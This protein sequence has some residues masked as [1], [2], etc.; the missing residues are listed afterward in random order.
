[1]NSIIT[2]IVF[3]QKIFSVNRK[4]I[5]FKGGFRSHADQYQWA[6]RFGVFGGDEKNIFCAG[7]EITHDSSGNIIQGIKHAEAQLTG[8]LGADFSYS[9][10]ITLGNGADAHLQFRIS[11]EGRYGIRLRN[12]DVP[13]LK[14]K[15]RPESFNCSNKVNE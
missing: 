5:L 15:S 2:I 14:I 3:L 1:M 11:D 4:T 8:L 6:N 10:T 9:A 13:P 12:K 7:G